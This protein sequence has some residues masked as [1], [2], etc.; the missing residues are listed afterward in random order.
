MRAARMRCD[1][2]YSDFAASS[3]SASA[4]QPAPPWRPPADVH[5]AA[6]SQAARSRIR[7]TAAGSGPFHGATLGARRVRGVSTR[8][9]ARDVRAVPRGGS[10]DHPRRVPGMLQGAGPLGR[11]LAERLHAAPWAGFNIVAFYDDDPAKCG[12]SIAGHT[13]VGDT[14]GLV[15][16]VG[17][18][19]VDQ[20][21]IALPLRA[22]ARIREILI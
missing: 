5:A 2:R 20:V 9:H 4:L 6:A 19:H 22:E 21:W 1:F 7:D 14:H 8:R 18:G 11:L 16:D 17:R 13:V 12:Q 15:G 10:H 3:R